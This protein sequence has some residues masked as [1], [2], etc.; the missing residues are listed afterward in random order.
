MYILKEKRVECLAD[1]EDRR[2]RQNY[3][4]TVHFPEAKLMTSR[5]KIQFAEVICRASNKLE[6]NC[7]Y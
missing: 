6:L 2:S 3:L 4:L 5:A 7:Q 1:L